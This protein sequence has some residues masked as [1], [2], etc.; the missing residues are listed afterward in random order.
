MMKEPDADEMGGPPDGD[1]DDQ[2]GQGDPRSKAADTWT[3]DRIEGDQALVTNGQKRVSF[4][5]AMLPKGA[6][7]GDQLDPDM[8]AILSNDP[9][10]DRNMAE[11]EPDPND[12]MDMGGSMK[13]R[14]M[15]DDMGDDDPGI[16]IK[17]TSPMT[18]MR[19][20]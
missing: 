2:M 7:P 9:S 15:S 12:T 10:G 17:P 18:R 16:S 1:P 4:P 5:A 13:R 3:V 11:Q 14:P 19:T 6:K 8:G 20:R